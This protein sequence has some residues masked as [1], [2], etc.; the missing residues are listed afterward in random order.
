M[1]ILFFLGEAAWHTGN[2]FQVGLHL[3]PELTFHFSYI[4]LAHNCLF[5]MKY[6]LSAFSV[7][8]FQNDLIS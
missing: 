5:H 4:Y 1:R 6:I 3:F 8:R 7:V 2:V